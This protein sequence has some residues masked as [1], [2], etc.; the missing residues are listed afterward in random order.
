MGGDDEIRG[1]AVVD[2]DVV[3]STI[4]GVGF[5]PFGLEGLAPC[6]VLEAGP[7]FRHTGTKDRAVL[8]ENDGRAAV[9]ARHDDHGR[10]DGEPDEM[11]I[12]L[13]GE[14][15][16]GGEQAFLLLQVGQMHENGF[17]AHDVP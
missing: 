10:D 3:K 16:S 12:V 6:R 15:D 1:S 17:V 5:T 11:R 4:T 9:A 14:R 7:E 2:D 13:A 8:L